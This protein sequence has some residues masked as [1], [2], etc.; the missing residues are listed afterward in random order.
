MKT[1][2]AITIL[3]AVVSAFSLRAENT[4]SASTPYDPAPDH[5]WNRLNKAL[6]IRTDADGTQFGFNEPDILYWVGTKHLLDQ[7][8]HQQ[9]LAILDEFIHSHG[10]RL[11]HDPVK[12][13]LL[14]R[15]CGNFLIGSAGRGPIRLFRKSAK[16]S[17]AAWRS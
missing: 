13:A 5:L 17:K 3:S 9:A 7:P 6:F 2:I 4:P 10:E 1:L 15:D 14:Q 8:S 12:R 16:G 11:I